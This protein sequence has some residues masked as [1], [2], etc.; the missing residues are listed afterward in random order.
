M[1]ETITKES[2]LWV[3]FYEEL[4]AKLLEYEKRQK[5]LIDFLKQAGVKGGLLD[6]DT[7]GN[8]ILLEETDPFTFFALI[9]K[10]GRDERNKILESLKDS[11]DLKEVVPKAFH[12]VPNAFAVKSWFFRYKANRNKEDISILWGLFK[13]VM[14]NSVSEEMFSKVLELSSVGKSKLT[15]AL[16]WMKP[17]HYL[18]IDSQTKPYLKI[19]G[20]KTDFSNYLEY[21]RIIND[22]RTKLPNKGLYEISYDAWVKK[23]TEKEQRKRDQGKGDIDEEKPGIKSPPIE[24]YTKEMALQDLFMAENDFD[25]IIEMLLRK[26]NIILQGPP[27][28]GKTF[29]AK[30]IAFSILEEKNNEKVEMIQFHQSYS[31]EDFIQGFRPS[32]RGEF[33]L[34]NG[35]FYSFCKKAQ[36]DPEGEYFFIIDEINRGNLSK[37]F[38]ELLMLIE[39]DKRGPEFQVPL[40]YSQSSTD[41]FYIPEKLYLIGTMNTADRSLAMVDYALR[42]RFCFISLK[43]QFENEKFKKELKDKGVS[44]G[45]IEKIISKMTNFNEKIANDNNLG[46]GFKIGHSYF[47]PYDNIKS[48]ENWY[49]DV[50]SL[51][52]APLIREYWFDSPEKAEKEIEQLMA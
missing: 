50:I 18:P 4:S 39:Y 35:I 11:L 41:K 51:E 40:T 48:E 2:Y 29:I 43:P 37:I 12:G 28:V 49:R 26:K 38:G 16:F 33:E 25:H 52:I 20:I 32:E 22:V 36:C 14:K 6:K 27:G 30:R 15:Q 42:R 17:R 9:N 5:Q 7:N 21:M 8:K 24:E 45:L 1:K 47:C 31:Y 19:I 23:Q 10:Y 34:K 3:P 13:E 44:N 46:P